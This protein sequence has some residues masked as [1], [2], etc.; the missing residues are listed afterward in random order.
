MAKE[1]L[2]SQK[3][4]DRL[5]KMLRAFENGE[6]TQIQHRRRSIAVG[7][8]KGLF[9]KAYVRITPGETETVECYLDTDDTGEEITVTCEITGGGAKLNEVM[10][11][12]TNGRMFYVTYD[13]DDELWRPFFPFQY[14]EITHHDVVDG[15]KFESKLYECT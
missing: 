8:G 11:R 10:P 4:H 7:G 3:D 9:R 14:I 13:S 12:L 2:V 6:F 1:F 5:Q 15:V